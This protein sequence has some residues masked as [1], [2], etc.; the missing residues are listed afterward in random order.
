MLVPAVGQYTPSELWLQTSHAVLPASFWNL[1]AS[2]L[3][4]EPIPSLGCTVPA[5]Q[6]VCPVLLVVAKWP[7]VALVH[8]PALL[9]LAAFE[10]MPCS[11]GSGA[12][13]R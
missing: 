7:A 8:S 9:R 5:A 2:H 11:R 6:G 3:V 4:Q 13:A 12:A 1:P 10:Y